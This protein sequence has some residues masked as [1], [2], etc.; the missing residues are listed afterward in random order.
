VTVTLH[1]FSLREGSEVLQPD[2]SSPTQPAGHAPI[3]PKP[4]G[5]PD[6]EAQQQAETT[7][8]SF[9]TSIGLAFHEVQRGLYIDTLGWIF[10][11]PETKS[12]RRSTCP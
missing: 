7:L 6:Y 5:E 10:D 1:H 9:L 3:P 12:S 2:G 4:N 11:S 8:F